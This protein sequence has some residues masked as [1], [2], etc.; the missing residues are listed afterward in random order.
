[1]RF[2][3]KVRTNS[4]GKLREEFFIFGGKSE[5]CAKSTG[6][7]RDHIHLRTEACHAENI[8]DMSQV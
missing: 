6:E 2:P 7:L 5:K 4:Y 3:A 8:R 1:M